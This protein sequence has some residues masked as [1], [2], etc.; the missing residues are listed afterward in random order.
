MNLAIAQGR[1]AAILPAEEQPEAWRTVNA[2][3]KLVLPGPVDLFAAWTDEAPDLEAL[4]RQAALG[5]F[6]T[7]GL[8]VRGAVRTE[9]L[10]ADSV[11][12]LALW[13]AEAI[14]AAWP[15]RGAA[16][17]RLGS[18]AAV[19]AQPETAAA[20]A[21][22]ASAS[23]HGGRSVPLDVAVA[24]AYTALVVEGGLGLPEL[25]NRLATEPARRLGLYP[26]KGALLPGSSADV[27]VFDPEPT[28]VYAGPNESLQGVRLVG[29]PVFSLLR[30]FILLLNDQVHQRPGFGRVQPGVT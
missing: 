2:Q 9:A 10:R 11:L 20:F 24:L 7:I 16:G 21:A 30:G 27:L 25:A 26:G 3:G 12:D 6:T 5:G 23:P 14:D 13:S 1:I 29:A 4:T 19:R 28:R 15:K 18:L 22:L 8:G 17:P